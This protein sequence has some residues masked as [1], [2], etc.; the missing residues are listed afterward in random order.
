MMTIC[1]KWWV[2]PDWTTIFGYDVKIKSIH[3]QEFCNKCVGSFIN[4]YNLNWEVILSV[5]LPLKLV[6]SWLYQ[7]QDLALKSSIIVVRKEP[8]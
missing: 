4:W 1:M 6:L 5:V 7:L 2:N 3:E 8:F